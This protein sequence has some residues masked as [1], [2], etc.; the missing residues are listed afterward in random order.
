MKVTVPVNAWNEHVTYGHP[1][2]YGGLSEARV[3]G[4]SYLSDDDLPW[5]RQSKR[6]GDNHVGVLAAV[7]SNGKQLRAAMIEIRPHELA[8]FCQAYLAAYDKED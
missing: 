4:L 3:H 5:D 6:R 8:E 2:A 1:V 7:K